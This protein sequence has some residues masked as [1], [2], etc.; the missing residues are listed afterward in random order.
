MTRFSA[1][2]ASPTG[3]RR[4]FFALLLLTPVLIAG[5]M[6]TSCEEPKGAQTAE[7]TAERT[8]EEV[9]AIGVARQFLSLLVAKQWAPA[10]SLFDDKMREAMPVGTLATTWKKVQNETGA[11]ESVTDT[12]V[13]AQPPYRSVLL[14]VSYQAATGTMKV[15]VDANDKIAGLWFSEAQEK[16]G[17][18]KG[19]EAPPLVPDADLPEGLVG[20]TIMVGAEG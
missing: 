13:E 19:G 11:Y 1:P 18:K 17:A 8:P 12:R 7:A 14:T 6:M 2:S 5:L 3:G 15:V 4:I 20:Q 16:P 10:A 9:R